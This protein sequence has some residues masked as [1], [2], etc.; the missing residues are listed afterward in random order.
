MNTNLLFNC[1]WY[2]G[3]T[4]ELMAEVLKLSPEQFYEKAFG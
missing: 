3:A 1:M 4:P 2:A